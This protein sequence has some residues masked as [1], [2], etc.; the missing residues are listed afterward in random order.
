MRNTEVK[1]KNSNI[2]LVIRIISILVILVCIGIIIYRYFNLKEAD[3]IIDSINSDITLNDKNIEVNGATANL[4]DTDISSLKLKNSDTVGYLKVNGTNINYPVVQSSD[5]D[6]Y[7]KHSFDKS[8]SQAGWIF[9]DY[10]NNINKLD[11]NTI[12]YGHNML[13]GTMFSNLTKMLDKSFFNDSN[14]TYI[15]LITENKTTL[16]KI[17]SVYVTNPDTYYMTIGF[18][19]SNEYSDFLNNI[20]N[21]SI[22]DF[23][24]NIN[25]DDKILTLSTCTNL[26]TKRLVIHAKLIYEQEK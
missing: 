25:S 1:R 21:K 14:N 17:F 13:N 8:Y 6:Y 19:S 5:N 20:K 9:L 7:L 18:S 10:R 15:N 2:I 4:I 3:K 12:I 26:N 11:Q 24:E 22:Y 16:W 23:E